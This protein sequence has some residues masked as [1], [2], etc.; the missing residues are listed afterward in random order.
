MGRDGKTPYERA[1]GKKSKLLGLEFGEVLNFRR[2]RVPGKLAKLDMV[3]EDGVF[4]GYRAN[5]ETVVGTADGV[6]RTRT[7]QRKSADGRARAC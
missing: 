3:W 7:V 2:T 4:L 6:F 1:R 5:S